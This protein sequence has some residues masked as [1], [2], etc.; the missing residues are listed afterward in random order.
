MP[1]ACQPRSTSNGVVSLSETFNVLL[2]DRHAARYT[3]TVDTSLLSLLGRD[4]MAYDAFSRHTSNRISRGRRGSLGA[5]KYSASVTI[6][7]ASL[8]SCVTS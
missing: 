3:G 7:N 1:A 5:V 2:C 4:T 6:D 8:R